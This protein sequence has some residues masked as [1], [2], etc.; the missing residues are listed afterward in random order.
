M[1]A[2][3]AEKRNLNELIEGLKIPAVDIEAVKRD[4]AE[5]AEARAQVKIA[6]IQLEHSKQKTLELME[7]IKKRDD[8]ERKKVQEAIRK[9]EQL[10]AEKKAAVEAQLTALAQKLEENKEEKDTESI[11]KDIA[12]AQEYRDVLVADE[13]KIQELKVQVEQVV[14]HDQKNQEQRPQILDDESD[15]SEVPSSFSQGQV[16]SQLSQ[17]EI[18]EKLL[19]LHQESQ[20]RDAS[21]SAK[22]LSFS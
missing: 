6:Q 4:E 22:F 15:S 17:G 18:L 16:L 9:E 13:E 19:L 12:H 7:E 21:S 5:K 10:V 3:F 20:A 8:E 14:E 11:K 1:E 2:E